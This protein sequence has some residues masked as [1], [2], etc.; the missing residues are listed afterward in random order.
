MLTL[1]GV[2]STRTLD[3]STR[4]SPSGRLVESS[5]MDAPDGSRSVFPN[6]TPPAA[7]SPVLTAYV[8]AIRL[9]PEPLW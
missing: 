9:E 5:R 7:L 2:V 4:G 3:A 6:T 1:G 8:K